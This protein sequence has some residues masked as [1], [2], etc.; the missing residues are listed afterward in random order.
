MDEDATGQGTTPEDVASLARWRETTRA[1]G[2]RRLPRAPRRVRDDV[3]DPGRGRLHAG[4]ASPA[5][6][7][8]A[9]LGLPGRVPV[10]PRRPGRRC[11]A[12]RFWTMRQY[13]GFATAAETNERFRYL[14]TQ[15]QTGLSVAFDLPTQ[16]GYDS[17][18]PE[19]EGEVGRV[20]VPIS[21]LADME[22]LFDGHPAGRGQHLDDD[23]LDGRRSS[24]ALYVAAAE[25]QGGTPVGGE[26]DRSRTTSSRSTSP[27]GRGSTRRGPSMRLVTD[28]F[29][30]ARRELPKWNTISISG[31]HMREAGATGGPGAGLHPRRRDRLRARRRS[32]RGLAIDDFAPRLSLLL[33]RLVRAVR[34]GRQVPGGPPDVGPDHEGAVRGHEPQVDDVPLPHPDRGLER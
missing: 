1:E 15:G 20:G 18:A 19:A 9:D 12:S 28:V 3:R 13:A 6:T 21:S 23:Q 17:D 24:L 14:L 34:G 31:Y 32:A 27:A 16:M 4:R 11:T 22:T 2:G 10:H 8:T 5:S 26:R 7:R 30:F 29:E 33:R 25:K